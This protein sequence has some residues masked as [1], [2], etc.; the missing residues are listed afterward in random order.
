M[1]NVLRALRYFQPDLR[2]IAFAFGLLLLSTGANLLKPWPLAVIVDSVLGN[3]AL[4]HT[5]T[6]AQNWDKSAL[7]A[8]LGLAIVLFHT[9]YGALTAWQNFIS[10]K[11]GLRG[12]ARVRTA[13]FL[14]LQRLSLRFHQG[15]SQGDVIYR[16]SWDTYAF[17]TLFQ[18]GVFT[19]AQAT[20]S[21]SLM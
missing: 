14:W 6:F 2:R 8:L 21:L 4:P 16:V 13:V 17:Q 5:L 10:I 11:T 15:T 20:L 7:L 1:R 18:Q 19:F 12:L 3:K 9:G